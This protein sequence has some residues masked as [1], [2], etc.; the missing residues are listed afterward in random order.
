MKRTLYITRTIT[1]FMLLSNSFVAV[2]TDNDLVTVGCGLLI[3][4]QIWNQVDFERKIRIAI[5]KHLQ[6]NQ[7]P[8]KEAE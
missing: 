1:M 6:A 3:L 7:Q 2:N 4:F 5:A 8:K